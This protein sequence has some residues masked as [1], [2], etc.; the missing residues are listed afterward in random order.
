MDLCI[1]DFD[2][3]LAV[4]DSRVVVVRNGQEIRMTSREFAEFPINNSTDQVDF[5]DFGRVEG[6]LIKHT[7]DE[8][9]RLNREGH[10]V[11][12]VTARA[13]AKPVE[14]FLKSELGWSPPVVATSGSEGKGPW[15]QNQL[16]QEEYI[17]VVVYEDCRKNIRSLTI[18]NIILFIER[19]I[20]S[21]LIDE[22]YISGKVVKRSVE[23][24]I[25]KIICYCRKVSKK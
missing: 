24:F 1:F 3:T 23:C 9:E 21:Y 6:T 22:I 16:Q 5:G 15:L 17:R 13:I 14:E 18:L 19:R 10:D 7:A 8:M 4:T 11:W 25:T 20:I 2:D 12:I